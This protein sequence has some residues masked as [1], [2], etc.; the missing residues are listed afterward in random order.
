MSL[1]HVP[2]E[3]LWRHIGLCAHETLQLPRHRRVRLD[4]HGAAEV[5]QLEGLQLLGEEDVGPLDVPVDDAVLV[6][7][8]HRLQKLSGCKVTVA[9]KSLILLYQFLLR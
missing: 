6:E 2:G 5:A 9:H 7:T 1:A 3:D 8:G 4:L